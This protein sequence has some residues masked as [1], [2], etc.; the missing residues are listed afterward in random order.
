[1]KLLLLILGFL[2]IWTS[3][4]FAQTEPKVKP[5]TLSSQEVLWLV[6]SLSVLPYRESAPLINFIQQKEAASDT[7]RISKPSKKDEPQ[8]KR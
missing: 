4:V 6:R 3:V 1:L 8:K 7:A 2:T 5:L